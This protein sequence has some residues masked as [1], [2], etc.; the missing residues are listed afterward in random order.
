M[1]CCEMR[2]MVTSELQHIPNSRKL[3][4]QLLRMAYWN[5]RMHS[6]GRKATCIGMSAA[7]VLKE[8]IALLV[9]TQG[10]SREDFVFSREF[11]AAAS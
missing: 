8:C 11:F 5:W 2:A 9:R 10:L 3:P 4:Q 1:T 6:L 7:E